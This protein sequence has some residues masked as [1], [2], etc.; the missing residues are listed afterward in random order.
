LTSLI[1]CPW[2][3]GL[4]NA[5]EP[6]L[7]TAAHLI[8]RVVA[9]LRGLRVVAGAPALLLAWHPVRSGQ[10]TRPPVST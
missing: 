9:R 4:G 2:F 6:I 5:L 3:R 7:I 1:A 8:W 10:A